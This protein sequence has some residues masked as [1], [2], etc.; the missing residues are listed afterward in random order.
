[1]IEVR[2]TAFEQGERIPLRYTGEG[3]D[4]SPPITWTCDTPGVEEF[5]LICDDPDAPTPE[6]F[7]HWLVYRIPADVRELPEG[8]H[9]GAYEGINSFGQLGY[10]GPMPPPPHGTHRYFFRVY[11][12]DAPLEL[13]SGATRAQLDEAMAGHVID[14]GELMGTYDRT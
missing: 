8:N 11:A 4:V 1:M 9:A 6:P 2:S 5:V 3:E 10:G 7:V 12:L 14:Q 13:A